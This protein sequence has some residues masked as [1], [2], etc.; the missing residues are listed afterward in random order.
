M[1]L[2]FILTFYVYEHVMPYLSALH[3][4]FLMYNMGLKYGYKSR[5]EVWRRR[6][7]NMDINGML[8][9]YNEAV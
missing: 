1:G 9:Q 2:L 3:N 5:S 7:G 8:G 4:G 6:V